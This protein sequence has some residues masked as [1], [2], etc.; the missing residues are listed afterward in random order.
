VANSPTGKSQAPATTARELAFQALKQI[1]GGAFAD[2]ALDRALKTSNIDRIDR[3]LATELIYGIIRRQ[4]TLDALIDQ[5]ATKP[6]SQQPPELRLILHIGLYQLRYLDHIPSSAAVNTTVDLAKN[7][8]LP[9]LAGFVN[10]LLRQYDR[11][12]DQSLPKSSNLATQIGLQQ[13][14]PDWIVQVYLDQFGPDETT[15]L[16]EWLNHPPTID[17]RINGMKTTIEQVEAQFQ[18]ADIGVQRLPYC[19]QALRLTG[20]AGAIQYL[21]GFTAGEWIIQDSSAQLVTALLDPQPGETIVDACAA[22]GGKTLHIAELMQDQGTVWAI[23]KTASRRRKIQQ[24]VDRLEF[25]C[26]QT[27]IADSRN[28]PEF[29]GQCDRVLV[30]APCSGL[31]TLNRHADA[32]WRQ[33]PES[34]TQLTQLQREILDQA[35]TW[36]KPGGILVYA[37]CTLHPAENEAI[38]EQFLA[39]NPD[40]QIDRPPASSPIFPLIA[41]PGWIKVLPHQHQ[42]DGFFMVRL[43]RPA[44]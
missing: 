16:C 5:L 11:E 2:V 34:V 15:Q 31:G 23:D 32:R 38:V 12:P 30:D 21:P 41:P 36:V 25:H 20:H 4:R 22:P 44:I 3:G 8:G 7:H 28:I 17:L 42:M 39:R 10:G 18:Q 35:A 43:N 14:F 9:G 27:K 6:A 24:N 29:V 37:T 19:P 40:W 1:Q 13:S 33:T 26:I